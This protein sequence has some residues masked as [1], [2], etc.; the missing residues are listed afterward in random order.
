MVVVGFGV[1]HYGGCGFF[2][3]GCDQCLK[4]L[5]VVVGSDIWV[6]GRGWVRCLGRW[7]WLGPVFGSVGRQRSPVF[8][9]NEVG[10][11]VSHDLSLSSLIVDR[12]A[13][14]GSVG[15]DWLMVGLKWWIC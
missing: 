10:F 8:G 4:G 14:F 5:W 2:F 7:S 13:G 1:G 6:V 9:S 11:G 15:W 12:Q 3:F